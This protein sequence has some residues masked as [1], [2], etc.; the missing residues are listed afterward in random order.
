MST[1]L[2]N[3]NNKEGIVMY[4]YLWVVPVIALVL[5]MAGCHGEGGPSIGVTI[6]APAAGASIDQGTAVNIAVTVTASAGADKVEFRIDGV[7][8]GTDTAAPFSY[9]WDT[10]AA[11]IADHTITVTAYDVSTPVKTATATRTVSVELPPTAPPTVEITS[12]E[13]GDTV[14]GDFEVV[15]TAT[16]QE[17]GEDIDHIDITVDGITQRI[18][19]ASG[20]K[21][22]DSTQLSNGT[23]AITAVATDTLTVTGSDTIDV[24]VD[25]FTV[26]VED[27][28]VASGGSTTVS[29]KMTD[30]TGVAGFQMTINYD[31]VALQVVGGDAGVQLG[32]SAAA[33]SPLLVRDTTTAG[34][35]TIAVAGTTNFDAAKDE[36]LTI[37]FG[38]LGPTGDT[39]ID[40]DETGGA[41]TPLAFKD[42]TGSDISP[43]PVAVD[44]TVTVQ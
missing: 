11:T 38:S 37:N 36:I 4:K 19:A 16:A 43:Q 13:D 40:I 26:Y 39:D 1:L 17:P 15:V 33:A 18:N 34:V 14:S 10:S 12:P 20:I 35:I 22:F 42:N 32:E 8:V 2:A 41:P 23:H 7:L 3:R 24:T 21:T 31:Q 30:T 27:T 5:V 9:V 25:N 29:V 6:T 44:G 28:N